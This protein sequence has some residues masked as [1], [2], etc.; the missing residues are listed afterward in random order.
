MDKG[1]EAPAQNGLDP[2]L[3]AL[4]KIEAEPAA[5]RRPAERTRGD[6]GEPDFHTLFSEE[7]PEA[8]GRG[9]RHH[10]DRSSPRSRR[11]RTIPSPTSRTRTTTRRS[12]PGK[13]KRAPRLHELLGKYMKAE[14]PEEK[15]KFR[16]QLISAFWELGGRV[17][18]RAGRDLILPKRLLLRFGILSPGFLTPELQ[19]M[20]SRIVYENTYGE[21]VYYVDEWLE[22]ISTGA[23]AAVHRGRDQAER[24]QGQRAEGPGRRGEEEGPAG[25][26]DHPPEGQDFAA[27]RARR[28]AQGAGGA[29]HPAR[30]GTTTTA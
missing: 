2:D 6:A 20:V 24:R 22:R 19:D 18:Y 8:P 13:V 15:S 3:A 7:K 10:Q 12:S 17:A 21:P 23:R 25:Q 30:A 9:R 29:A 5:R 4:L 28:A 11:S 14:D 16:A 27:R 1:K 26:R